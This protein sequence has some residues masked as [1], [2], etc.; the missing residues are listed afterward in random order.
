MEA[1]GENL[2]LTVPSIHTTGIE[3]DFE[4]AQEQKFTT[5]LACKRYLGDR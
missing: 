5:F 2:Y 3:T 4:R 1:A